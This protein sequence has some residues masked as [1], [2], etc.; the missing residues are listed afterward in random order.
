M[1]FP[2]I[3]LRIFFRLL[4]EKKYLSTDFIQKKLPYIK[5]IEDY[6]HLDKLDKDGNFY[7]KYQTWVINSFVDLGLIDYKNKE[8]S[9]NDDY[10]KYIHNLFI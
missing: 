6:E 1:I 3:P 4:L 10:K 9:I 5:N 8:Y 7:D 2:Y